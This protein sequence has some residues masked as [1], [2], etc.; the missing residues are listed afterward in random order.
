MD[1]SDLWDEEPAE[2]RDEGA[3]T[4]ACERDDFWAE[5][6]AGMLGSFDGRDGRDLHVYAVGAGDEQLLVSMHEH[7]HH[8]LQWSTG[9]G[10]VAAMSGLLA[11]S[12]VRAEELNAVADYANRRARN[13]HEVF[14]TTVSCGVLGMDRARALLA[15]NRRYTRYLQQGL[16]L[17][18]DPTLWSW[19]FRESATQMLLRTLMQPSELS[20]VSKVGFDELTVAHLL[21][22]RPPDARL[23][24]VRTAGRWWNDTFAELLE[25]EPTRGGDTGDA[26]GRAIPTDADDVERLKKYE[27]TLLIPQLARTAHQRL[28]EMGMGCLDQDEYLTVA[29]RLQRSFSELAPASWQVELLVDR[30]PMTQEPLGAERE[31]IQLHSRRGVAQLAGS[32]DINET[33]FVLRQHGEHPTVLITYL[34]GRTYAAQFGLDELAAVPAVL[35]LAGWPRIDDEHIRRVPLALLSPPATPRQ[36]VE[37]FTNLPVCLLTALSL[38]REASLREQVLDCP[39]AFVLIDLPLSMQVKWW[40]EDGWT[41]R[42]AAIDLQSGH[43]LTM[44]LFQ[45]DELPNLLF[46]S[47]RSIAGFG[48]LAQL[49]DRHPDKLLTGLSPDEATMQSLTVVTAWLFASWWRLQEAENLDGE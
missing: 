30:R 33:T 44:L 46:V 32:D 28:G 25:L 14:A 21:A 10:L 15:R 18:G 49:L 42:F 45:L 38:T 26:W 11:G 19:Q 48:E 17:G 41:V 47:Y 6:D 29:T 27:E 34:T 3:L 2:D 37:S 1:L 22:I 4:F 36:M 16:S 20:S 39:A 5:S 7:L 40:V 35:A 24:R 12:G 43:G 31:R 8:E 13:V 23:H 9:W